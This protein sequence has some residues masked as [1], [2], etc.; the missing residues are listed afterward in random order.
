[1]RPD[2]ASVASAPL[3]RAPDHLHKVDGAPSE[4]ADRLFE[5]GDPA[6]P[7]AWLGPHDDSSG[8]IVRV[9]APGACGVEA[10]ARHGGRLLATLAACPAPG[11]DGLFAAR[12]R[13]RM[14]YHL[15]IR[16][17]EAVQMTEDPY[18]FGP[19]LGDVDLHLVSEGRHLE[20]GHRFGAQ[21]RLHEGVPGVSFA[22]WAPN[23]RRVAV[24]GDFNAWDGRRHPMRSRGAS[25]VWELFVPRL[26]AGEVYKYEITASDGTVAQKADP[27]ALRAELAPA[28]GSIVCAPEQHAWTDAC[29]M[30]ERAA[31]QAPTAPMSIYE[32]HTAS[33]RRPGGRV[34]SWDELTRDLVPYVVGL[35]F[36]HVE[37]MPITEHPFGGS[38]GYQPLGL[39]APTSRHGDATGLARFV[40]ACHAAGVGVLLDWV[41][42]HFARDPHGLA[43][44]DGTPLYEHGDEREGLHRGWG[45]AVYNFG[46][47]EVASYLVASALH[48]LERFHFDGLRVDAVASMLY[49]DYGREAGEWVPNVH[50]GHENLEAVDLLRRVNEA[51]ATHCP[52]AIVIAEESTSWSG[53]TAARTEGGLGF[54]YK[55]NM[56]WM[57]DTLRYFARDPVHR[58]HHHEDLT[59]G[60]LYA[61]SERFVLPVSHDE[62]VHGKR[63]LLGRMPGDDWQRHAGLRALYGLMW[64][65]PGKKLLFMGGEIAQE[66]EW[67]H[68]GELAWSDSQPPLA[69]G[70]TRLIADLNRLYTTEP[71]LHAWDSDGRGFRWSVVDDRAN[72]VLAWTRRGPRGA[73]F[74][75]VCNLTPVPRNGYRVGVPCGGCW[76]ERLNT[77]A[78]CYGGSNVGN[79]GGVEASDHGSHGMPWS[80][81]LELPPLG[82]LYLS[83]H[84]VAGAR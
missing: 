54:A 25:G 60:L 63:S 51:V 18:G 26:R 7:F 13:A 45:T 4:A 59:F 77:D 50:G 14:P 23:A 52:G 80:V 69:A 78:T 38:W 68:D 57:N 11:C 39:F 66:G 81:A 73:S 65:H 28:T 41:P 44:F 36:T 29:W 70:V 49:R 64:A 43:C 67:S 27:V 62:V 34:P 15:C 20:L 82:V 35:G 37:L 22:V 31:R 6:D 1:M 3:S 21:V 55:W 9:L 84:G 76:H 53:V 5:H 12:L 58:S 19:L 10:R 61:F 33:W 47:N 32:V 17:P 30:A 72:S 2:P 79:S 75:V 74:L 24:V 16:W 71:A 56:G 48:W 40:D 42:G 83:S 8:R 46:R